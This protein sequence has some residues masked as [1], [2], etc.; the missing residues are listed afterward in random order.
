MTAEPTTDE[1]PQAAPDRVRNITVRGVTARVSVRPGVGRHTEAPPLLLCNGI[2]LSL[3]GLQG[4]V[5]HL[6][7]ERGVV[8]FDVPGVGGSALPPL[9]YTIAGLSSWVTALMGRLGHRRFDVLGIS[10]GGGLAQ[11]LAVQSPRKVRRVVLVA[12]G[13]GMLM[14]PASPK[15]LRIMSTPRRHR[16]PA[17]AREVAGTIYGGSMRTDPAHGASLLHAATRA[18][19][20]RGYYYQLLAMTGWSSTPF[21]GLLRQPTLVLGGDDDPIIPV[22]NPRLQARLIPRARLHVY[23]G[24]HLDLITQAHQLAPVVDA[25]LDENETHG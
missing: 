6:D 24:G 2:G 25:F 8:R 10:W 5:D 11:Q 4:F 7:P 22:A 16:D 19:P 13:T 15:V 20:K 1:R 21:L 14:V 17:Y 3:E 23:R 18:G 12:T 9:P